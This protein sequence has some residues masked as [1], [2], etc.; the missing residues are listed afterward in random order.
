MSSTVRLALHYPEL[1]EDLLRA[2]WAGSVFLHHISLL[3]RD[4]DS[5]ALVFRA[6][7]PMDGRV[8]VRGS[9]WPAGHATQAKPSWE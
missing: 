4:P 7:P 8:R 2:R 5:G 6:N 9:K 1:R 3:E